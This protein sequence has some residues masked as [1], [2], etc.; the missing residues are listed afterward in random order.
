MGQRLFCVA[1]FTGLVVLAGASSARAGIAWGT[2]TLDASASATSSPNSQSFT[3]PTRSAPGSISAS[4][5]ANGTNGLQSA[6]VSLQVLITLFSPFPPGIIPGQLN[7]SGNTS[8]T[9][10]GFP[11][12]PGLASGAGASGTIG[13]LVENTSETLT[14]T[15]AVSDIAHGPMSV[16]IKNSSNVTVAS[17]FGPGTQNITLAPGAYTISFGVSAQHATGTGGSGTQSFVLT[18][19]PAS[20]ALLALASPLLLRRRRR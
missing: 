13:L 16:T 7:I 11:A 5:S 17:F 19:E 10:I 2:G 6:S 1:V 12:L 8:L 4:A 14:G 3:A 20:L 15:M 9:G 18:P